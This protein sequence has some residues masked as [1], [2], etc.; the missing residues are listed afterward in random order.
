MRDKGSLDN[1]KDIIKMKLNQAFYRYKKLLITLKYF[2]KCPKYLKRYL[3]DNFF[4][5]RTEMPIKITPFLKLTCP[6][7]IDLGLPWFSY[8]AIDFLNDYLKP[9]MSVFEWGSGGSSIYFANRCKSVYSIENNKQ[10]YVSLQVK[11]SKLFLSNLKLGLV[12]VG[13]TANEDDY[14]QSIGSVKYDVISVDG[15]E[16]SPESR[17]LCFYK[18][19][20]NINP[21]GIIIIDDSYLYED[22]RKHNKAKRF[23]VL[24][25]VGP[26]R[27]GVTTTDVYFY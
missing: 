4:H 16:F 2:I 5:K 17:K 19:E 25:S 13:L 1:D 10:W 7:P 11:I 15:Y 20:S 18:A 3:G 26:A 12:E 24:R 27:L 9:F 23:M 22:I 14:I 21:G 6:S 8:S